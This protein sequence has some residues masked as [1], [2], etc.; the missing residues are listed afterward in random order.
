M[1]QELLR[2][3]QRASKSPN[4]LSVCSVLLEQLLPKSVC[5]L[6]GELPDQGGGACA[7]SVSA[8]DSKTMRY[9]RCGC[10]CG[11]LYVVGGGKR[12]V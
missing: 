7:N 12:Y 11:C 6:S 4:P 3:Y 1:E 10:V 5:E 2:A 8:M 9:S